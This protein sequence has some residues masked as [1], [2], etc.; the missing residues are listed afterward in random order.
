M[1][2]ITIPLA[3]LAVTAISA[4]GAQAATAS[5][6]KL[7]ST[8]K[9]KILETSSG[10]TLYAFTHDPKNKDTCVAI[11]GCAAVWPLLTVSG[12]PSAGPGV[13]AR[14]LGTINVGG[15]HQ[16]TYAGHALYLY[17]AEPKGTSYIGFSEFG[18]A[19]DALT[20]SGGL[21]K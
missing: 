7:V 2:R 13:K 17:S 20:A 12:K 3:T 15:K 1:N 21:V 8:S 19:W 6:V 16:V 4:V 11:S 5:T 14:K 9:G 10:K 18:G